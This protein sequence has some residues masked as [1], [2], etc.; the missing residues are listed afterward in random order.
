M[1]Q[2]TTSWRTGKSGNPNGRPPMRTR[3]L[4]TALREIGAESVA[5][6]ENR[7]AVASLVW[8]ALR[9][10]KLELDSGTHLQLTAKEWLDLLKWVHQHVD[11]GLNRKDQY[12]EAHDQQSQLDELLADLDVSSDASEAESESVPAPTPTAVPTP[13]SPPEPLLHTQS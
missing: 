11:G 4:A 3:P 6:R 5:E 2:T 8:Q 7:T 13:S 1:A 12:T 9:T 10:G